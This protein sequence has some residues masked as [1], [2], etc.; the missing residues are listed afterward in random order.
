MALDPMLQTTR[1]SRWHLYH[2]L[3]R[4]TGFTNHHW[5]ISLDAWAQMSDAEQ[6]G[7]IS[8]VRQHIKPA[9]APQPVQAEGWGAF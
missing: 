6:A 8:S 7:H 5:G 1:W 3:V 4:Q 9:P 2:E